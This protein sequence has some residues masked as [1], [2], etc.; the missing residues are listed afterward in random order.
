MQIILDRFQVRAKNSPNTIIS[1]PKIYLIIHV[2]VNLGSQEAMYILNPEKFGG[3]SKQ[4]ENVSG[5]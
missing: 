1:R 4:V 2:K 3:W 5:R